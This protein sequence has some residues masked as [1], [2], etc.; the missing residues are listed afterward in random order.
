MTFDR[1]VSGLE[2]MLHKC[3]VCDGRQRIVIIDEDDPG[4]FPDSEPENCAYCGCERE[5]VVIRIV[6]ESAPYPAEQAKA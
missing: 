2:M 3:P 5:T 4:H 1:R 6:S